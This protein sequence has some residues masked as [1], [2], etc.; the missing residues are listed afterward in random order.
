MNLF[1]RVSNL[2]RPLPQHIGILREH[3]DHD[4][5]RRVRKIADHIL[6]QLRE[7]HIQRGHALGSPLP[8]I[9]DYLIDAAV[10]LTLQLHREISAIRFGYR[11]EA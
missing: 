2:R 6:Q 5:L 9:G 1:D 3:L 4:R 10:A 8:H 7:F 11:R